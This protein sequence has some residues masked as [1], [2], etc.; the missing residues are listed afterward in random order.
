MRCGEVQ[1]YVTALLHT[2]MYFGLFAGKFELN[3]MSGCGHVVHEDV[4]DK[5]SGAKTQ[6]I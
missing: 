1:L 5:V 6:H 3:V 4:P 2:Y